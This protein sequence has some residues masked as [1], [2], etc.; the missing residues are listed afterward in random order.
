MLDQF[1][2][3]SIIETTVRVDV[4][5]E[6]AVDEDGV[7]RDV[8][9]GFWGEVIDRFFVGVDQA[10]PVFSGATPTSI[11]EAIGRILYVGLVQLGYLPLRFG[12]VSLIFGVFGALH[13]DHLLLSWIGS[14]GGLEREVMSQ[15]IDVGVRNCDRGILCDILGRHAVPE[16]P[17]DI[18]M[19]RL[20]LQC[21][22]VQFVAGA[23]YPLHRMRL[24]RLRPHL[25]SPSH[26]M[27]IIERL[28]PSSRA[29]SEMIQTEATNSD[30]ER[31]LG[32]LRRF[33]RDINS[34]LL[35]LF[36][37]F[38]SGSDN[39]SFAAINV[40]FVPHLRGL[41]RRI[42]AHTCSQT[43]DL[44]TSYMTYNEFAAETRAIL[45]AGHWEM[46]FV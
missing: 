3:D 32:Y 36:C 31:V 19:R 40:N 14:L 12:L 28:R 1:S 44:P 45:Q 11:W 38:V 5:G 20:A 30:E 26:T 37:R 23:M 33:I 29:V 18:N 42:V 24:E 17:T 10:A 39:L 15:A 46:D 27:G 43:L 35:R 25:I 41:A 8:L 21:A 6:Q 16:L 34:D 7:F 13:D 9:S 22:E 2:D 4:V